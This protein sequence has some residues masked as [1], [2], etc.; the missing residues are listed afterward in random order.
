MNERAVIFGCE[1]ES[2]VGILHAPLDRRHLPGVLIVVGG[3]QYRVGS[4]RQFTLM[5]RSLAAAGH[6]VLRFDYRGMGDSTG[7]PRTFDAVAADIRAAVDTFFALAPDMSGVVLWGLCDAASAALMYC[8]EDDRVVGV[9]LANPWVRTGAGEARAY[10][11]H[12]YSRRILQ[13]EFWRKVGRFEFD[14]LGSIRDFHRKLRSARRSAEPVEPNGFVDRMRSGLERFEGRVLVLISGRDLTAQE[15]VDLRTRDPRWRRL[16][17]RESVET[18]E[19][20]DAD[21]TFSSGEA[22]GSA[23]RHTIDWLSAGARLAPDASRS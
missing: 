13:R 17:A 15:F 11:R 1:G 10:V 19:L 16:L 8:R 9:A 4:H 5:A 12:Y 2:L 21:H 7:Q 23:T 14:V 3:P 18:V 22:L 20:H 6:Y